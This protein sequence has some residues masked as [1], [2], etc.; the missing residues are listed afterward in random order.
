MRFITLIASFLLG[1]TFSLSAQQTKKVEFTYIYRVP[2]N[3]SIEQAKRL[4]LERTKLEAIAATF[5]TNISQ[6]NSTLVSNQN[7]ISNID[8]QTITSS[9]VQGEWIETIEEPQYDIAFKQDLIIITCK[10]KGIIREFVSAPINI[11]SKI[12]RNSVDDRNESS[13]F[14]SGDEMYLSFQS[15]VDGFL[16]VYLLDNNGDVFCLLPYRNRS[17]GIQKISANTPYVFFSK[18]NMPLAERRYVDEYTLTSERGIE[19]NEV[20]IIF[21]TNPF[22]KVVDYDNGEL[23]PRRIDRASFLKWLAQLRNKDKNVNL[24][25]KQLTIK[26]Q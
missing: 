18:N 14:I 22:V 19:Y 12:L 11:K 6:H 15:P 16:A 17:D 24:T 13:V 9:D 4:A 23:T 1:V 7:G 2:E 21:T 25:I 20:Y 26:K 8:F 3:I 5:G 10:I